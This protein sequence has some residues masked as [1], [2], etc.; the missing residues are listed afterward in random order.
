MRRSRPKKS[1]TVLSCAITTALRCRL[2]NLRHGVRKEPH[3]R[4]IVSSSA[5]DR[6]DAAR[7]FLSGRPPAS[8]LV[9]VGASR[10]AADDLARA[11][12]R[13]AGSTFGLT[14]FSL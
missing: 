7:A 6:L 14:R 11:V 1:T 9:I 12:A 8:E 5:A 2:P 10:G 3:V 13:H 4:V